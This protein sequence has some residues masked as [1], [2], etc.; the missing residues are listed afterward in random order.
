MEE[1]Q[2]ETGRSIA[3]VVSELPPEA[4]QSAL[5]YLEGMAAVVAMQKAK[6]EA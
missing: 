5:S 3:E 6:E 2:R 1:K 4:Q